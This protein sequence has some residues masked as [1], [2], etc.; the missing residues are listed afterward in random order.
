MRIGIADNTSRKF[1]DDLIK[2][3]EAKG[4]EVRYEPGA[5][6]HIAQWADLYYIEWID[7][8]LN[9]LW[10]LYNGDPDNNRTSD[11]DNNKKPVIVCRMIDWDLWNAYVPF[12]EK[13]YIDFIDKA[14]CIAPHMQKYILEK[15]PD[16]EGKLKLIRPGVNTDKFTLKSKQTDGFQLGMALG[17]MWWP[18]NHMAGLDIFTSLYRQDKRWRLHIRG[19]HE[20][21]IYWP[22]MYEKYLDS[23]QIRDV[24]TLY[25]RVESMN[26]WYEDIDIL[27]HPGMKETFCY[28][29][30]EAMAKGIPA[31]VN[32]FY[33]SK[34][35]WPD[36]ML[37]QTH[38]E[39]N[40]KIN[41][42]VGNRKPDFVTKNFIK[43]NYSL[44]K[45]FKETDEY[46]GI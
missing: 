20:V 34:D 38:Q 1:T 42:I 15:A 10:K 31:V 32:E 8:N 41:T 21:G 3:W 22:V 37:Y 35:I 2:H 43:Q 26:D 17:D 14:I 9:Y 27:L 29:V 5:S 12:Y 16:Y 30:G 25:P 28:A 46:L 33:G 45:Y 44:E 18:K 39:A 13:N 19:Q 40:R 36:Y 6:E 24:V 23:R 7:N 4:H 11:W